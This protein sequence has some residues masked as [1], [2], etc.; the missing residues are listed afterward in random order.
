MQSKKIENTFK[1]E[2]TKDNSALLGRL[3]IVQDSTASNEGRNGSLVKVGPG[4]TKN[5]VLKIDAKLKGYDE[6]DSQKLREAEAG[7]WSR[8]C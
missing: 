5:L 1:Q 4:A 2:Q 7:E 8:H 3:N 6:S